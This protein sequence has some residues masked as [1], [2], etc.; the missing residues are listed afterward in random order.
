MI[1]RL[2]VGLAIPLVLAGCAGPTPT[3]SPTALATPSAISSPTS[4]GATAV[5]HGDGRF[6][7]EWVVGCG[8]FVEFAPDP[9]RPSTPGAYRPRSGA[10]L[11]TAVGHTD[12]DGTWIEVIDAHPDTG[13]VPP[14]EYAV[15][16]GV[17]LVDDTMTPGASEPFPV[18]GVP[19]PCTTP[20]TVDALTTILD[21]VVH[22]EPSGRCQVTAFAQPTDDGA[23]LTIAATGDIEC[24][25]FMG[26][27]PV[28]SILSVPEGANAPPGWYDHPLVTFEATIDPCEVAG[29]CVIRVGEALDPPPTVGVGDYL[30]IAG[31]RA[32]SDA[33]SHDY[34]GNV[35][36][37]SLGASECA[38]RLTVDD[39]TAAVRIAVD[40]S[41]PSNG[42]EGGCTI[43]VDAD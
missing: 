4:T 34:E 33:S 20:V 43:E 17:Y 8:V 31:E 5:L 39:S 7:C 30:V 11:R 9:P 14:G 13:P 15:V 16:A 32:T 25:A 1:R 19:S 10:V 26:C 37:P 28:L 23:A 18:A 38:Q 40:F 24:F 2:A 42:A 3:A 22:V 12:A 6:P 29:G 21:V 27:T 36:F 35:V 41:D